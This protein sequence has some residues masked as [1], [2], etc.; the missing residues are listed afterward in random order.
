MC[1]SRQVVGPCSWDASLERDCPEHEPL[2][3][4]TAD[5]TMTTLTDRHRPSPLPVVTSR[6]A[7]AAA[8]PR[9][10]EQRRAGP[11]GRPDSAQG[12]VSELDSGYD[13]LRSLSATPVGPPEVVVTAPT[14]DSEPAPDDTD[15]Y[16]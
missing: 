1:V 13:E 7:A 12:N 8:S 10:L 11:T 3:L 16:E 9:S 5:S 14:V 15:V 2:G 6:A 4:R